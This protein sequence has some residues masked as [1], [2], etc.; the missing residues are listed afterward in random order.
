MACPGQPFLQGFPSTAL[1]LRPFL[2]LHCALR[3]RLLSPMVTTGAQPRSCLLLGPGEPSKVLGVR[4]RKALCPQQR[5]W[6]GLG[7]PQTEAQVQTLPQ[8]L[9]LG[10]GG[11]PAH[12]RMGLSHP[13]SLCG[14]QRFLG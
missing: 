6:G 11:I 3:G 1:D 14:E 9:R 2:S 12:P 7:E 5:T 8:H 4:R 10:V 13:W